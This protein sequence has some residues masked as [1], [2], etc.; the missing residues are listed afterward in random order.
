M[1]MRMGWG[2]ISK[3][4]GMGIITT[5]MVEDGNKICPVQ[6]PIKLYHIIMLPFSLFTQL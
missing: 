4:C 2:K 6:L 3:I 1:G 5:G